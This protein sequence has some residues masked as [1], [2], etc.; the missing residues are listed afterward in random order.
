MEKIQEFV[1]YVDLRFYQ[2]LVHFLLPDVLKPIPSP[3]TQAIRNFSKNLETWLSSAMNCC[4]LEMLS[5]KLSAVIAFGQSLRRYT[6]LN[7]LAQAANAVLHNNSQI[8]QMLSDL[9]RV[10]FHSVHEQASWVCQCDSTFVSNIENEFK[11]ALQNRHS[12]EQWA[13]WLKTVIQ[14]VLQPFEDGDVYSLAARKFLL[15]WSFYRYTLNWKFGIFSKFNAF[16]KF[17]N[18]SMVIRDLTLRSAAS[19]GSFHLIRL[20]FDEYLF[21]I[22]EHEIAFKTDLPPIA[23]MTENGVSSF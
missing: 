18:S 9:N 14:T 22:I 16:L 1:K 4:P 5:A 3:L 23:V 6:S 21:Y 17:L 10:D 15:K 19:F 20:L 2:N 13:D 11:V 7:H 12:L 8:N